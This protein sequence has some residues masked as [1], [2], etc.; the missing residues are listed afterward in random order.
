MVSKHIVIAEVQHVQTLYHQ[1]RAR[2]KILSSKR[3]LSVIPSREQIICCDNT[4][5]YLKEA[6][7]VSCTNNCLDWKGIS[8]LFTNFRLLILIVDYY[9]LHCCYLVHSPIIPILNVQ[10]VFHC[11]IMLFWNRCSIALQYLLLHTLD[12]FINRTYII[13]LKMEQTSDQL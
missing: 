10:C 12:Y 13:D 4:R 2:F 6:Q 3:F 1:Q 8:S 7:N 11:E 5:G 9:I